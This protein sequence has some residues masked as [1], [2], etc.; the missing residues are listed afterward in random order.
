[1]T[2]LRQY[3]NQPQSLTVSGN[4]EITT[5]TGSIN[6]LLDEIKRQNVKL[7]KTERLSAIG[8]LA[9]QIGH[10]LRNPLAHEKRIILFEKERK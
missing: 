3:G 8:E 4:D 10:D 1:M 9:R 5:L 2:K 7:Q 6:G